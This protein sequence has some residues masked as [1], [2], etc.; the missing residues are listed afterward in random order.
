M[1][2]AKPHRLPAL[3]L[4]LLAL[5][6]AGPAA[7]DP[8]R[9]D[10]ASTVQVT[11]RRLGPINGT[12]LYIEHRLGEPAGELTEAVVLVR[13]DPFPTAT[14]FAV[15]SAREGDR[16]VHRLLDPADSSR[17]ITVPGVVQ[18]L[19]AGFV[20]P[21]PGAFQRDGDG[22]RVQAAIEARHDTVRVDDRW[23]LEGDRLVPVPAATP[24][25]LATALHGCTGSKIGLPVLITCL[26]KADPTYGDMQ[27]RWPDV[28]G[29]RGPSLRV[30]WLLS[31]VERAERAN[32]AI[33][34]A[35]AL[36]A[37]TCAAH[38]P[39]DADADEARLTE[40][41]AHLDADT[42]TQADAA[43]LQ[44]RCAPPTERADGAQLLALAHLLGQWVADR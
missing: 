35:R 14:P 29:A 44:K 28:P 19:Y 1:R 5:A 39:K 18:V 4:G 7:A 2:P 33:A 11:V 8:S 10:A 40:L 12:P 31:F 38:A 22:L 36:A 30:A 42:V 6:S 21:G 25:D 9:W 32:P 15:G 23:R 41:I 37:Q 17:P 27:R 24:G 34:K 13:R 3:I 20:V 16:M 26:T 43:W